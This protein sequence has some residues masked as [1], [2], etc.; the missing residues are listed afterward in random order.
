M[1]LRGQGKDDSKASKRHRRAASAMKERKQT[2][3]RHFYGMVASSPPACCENLMAGQH[4]GPSGWTALPDHQAQKLW[5]AAFSTTASSHD[6]AKRWRR[7]PI[8]REMASDAQQSEMY[9][10]LSEH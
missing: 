1:K 2:T 4:I 6:N 9:K 10:A 5:A 8:V 3:P 7:G